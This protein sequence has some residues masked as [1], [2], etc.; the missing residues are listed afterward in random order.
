MLIVVRIVADSSQNKISREQDVEHLGAE[1]YSLF[2]LSYTVA[3]VICC[4]ETL[5][6]EKLLFTA[7]I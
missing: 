6:D 5:Y 7:F 3:V 4:T 1:I 2:E